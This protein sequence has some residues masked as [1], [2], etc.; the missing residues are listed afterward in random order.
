ME[1]RQRGV[2]LT[3]FACGAIMA[4]LIVA[5][6]AVDGGAQMSA[7]VRAQAAAAEVARYAVDAAAPYA[8]DGQDGSGVALAAAGSAATRFV[9]LEFGFAI[10]ADGTLKVSTSTGVDTTF[11]QLI[12]IRKLTAKGQST[13]QLHPPR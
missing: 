4:L 3:V 13:V 5:G 9:D 1:S 11:L 12:G 7:H 6:L 8:V 10:D 2:S